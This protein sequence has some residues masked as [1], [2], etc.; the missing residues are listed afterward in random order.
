VKSPGQTHQQPLR[1]HPTTGPTAPL[2][3]HAE[4]T[5][6]SLSKADLERAII[7]RRPIGPN[8]W[9]ALGASKNKT[10]PGRRH[11]RPRLGDVPPRQLRLHRRHAKLAQE[12]VGLEQRA[13][14]VDISQVK[15]NG[16][17]S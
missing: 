15:G 16:P 5:Q 12:T 13:K 17:N 9:T 2:T 10:G 7:K 4:K 11:Q 1:E 6:R 8:A 14:Q 3:G